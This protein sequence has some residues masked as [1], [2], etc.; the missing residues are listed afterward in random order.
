MDIWSL[1]LNT[2]EIFPIC[3]RVNTTEWI[4]NG[5]GKILMIT[6]DSYVLFC[7]KPGSSP[8]PKKTVN[9]QPFTTHIPNHPNKTCW[10]RLMKWRW[11]YKRLFLWTTLYIHTSVN[12][13]A[14][15]YIHQLCVETRWL[16]VNLLRVLTNRNVYRERVN[17]ICAVDTSWW[18]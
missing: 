7:T 10:I 11:N 13:A 17:R 8:P 9:G 4:R 14:K 15:T 12:W 3:C 2:P 18:L 1:W 6:Q 5:W 16:L